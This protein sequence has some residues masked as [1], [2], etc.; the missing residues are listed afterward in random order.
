MKNNTL[1]TEQELARFKAVQNCQTYED[2]A[3]AIESFADDNGEIQG[4]KRPFNAVRMANYCRDF[5]KYY[6]SNQVDLLTRTY[7]IRQQALYIRHYTK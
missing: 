5:N 3:T 4:S 6:D 7:G 1:S 2:L